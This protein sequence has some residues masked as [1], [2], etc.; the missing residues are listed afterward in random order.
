M[1]IILL[2][3]GIFTYSSKLSAKIQII[4]VYNKKKNVFFFCFLATFVAL[5]TEGNE[6]TVHTALLREMHTLSL[7]NIY[8][9]KIKDIDISAISEL[10][11]GGIYH[12][13]LHRDRS[14][15]AEIDLNTKQERKRHQR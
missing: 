15:F 2:S 14:K 5:I 6:A 10:V 3:F 4:I 11:I 13:N 8:E 9:K 7:V 12:L 1:L